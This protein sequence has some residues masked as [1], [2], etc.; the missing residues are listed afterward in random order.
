V[1]TPVFAAPIVRCLNAKLLLLGKW[2][3]ATPHRK[4][5][6]FI[7]PRVIQPQ[8]P[9]IGLGRCGDWFNGGKVAGACFIGWV[10]AEQALWSLAEC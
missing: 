10:L 8:P 6:P 2:T 5:T 4:E 3:A 1:A 7:L 9:E